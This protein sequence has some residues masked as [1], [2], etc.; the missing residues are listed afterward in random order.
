MFPAY[1]LLGQAPAGI[2]KGLKML[3]S[4]FRGNDEQESNAAAGFSLRSYGA[5]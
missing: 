4:R 1:Y 3:D 2:Q 5:T